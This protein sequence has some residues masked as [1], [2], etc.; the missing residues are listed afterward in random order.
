M[1]SPVIQW[2]PPALA[3]LERFFRARLA[4]DQLE[5]ADSA[6]LKAD[7][8]A[9]LEEELAQSGVS[10]V[11]LEDLRLVLARMGESLP[12]AIGLATPP[13]AQPAVAAPP[14][15]M[16]GI[17][18]GPTSPGALSH[19]RWFL[20][21]AV[22]LPLGTF[23]FEVL[24]RGGAGMFFDPMPDVWHHFLVL[25]VPGAG[26]AFWRAQKPDA[27]LRLRRLLPW[28][29]G[30]GCASAGFYAFCFLP[31]MPLAGLGIIWFGL[32]LLPLA[33][34]LAFLA[35]W[36]AR[37]L[38]K[39][40]E[41]RSVQAPLRWGFRLTAILIL[42]LELPGFLTH[43]G[44]HQA[45]RAG[46]DAEGWA[47]ATGFIRRFGSEDTLLRS[48]YPGRGNSMLG[49][50]S[51]KDPAAWL[52]GWLQLSPGRGPSPWN[53]SQTTSRELYYRVTG[54]PFN[55]LAQPESARP[56]IHND[57]NRQGSWRNDEDRGGTRVAGRIEG[58][59]LAE[60]R[61]D[62]HCE[63]ASG[64]TWGEWTLTF[65]NNT[66]AP[67][68]ARC[69]IALPPGGFVSRV[70]LWVNGQPE[71]AA[72]STVS[73]VRAAY[74]SVAVVQR[75]DPVLVTQPDAGS[76][77]VQAFP[78]P[79]RGQLKTRITFTVPA[80]TDSKVWLPSIVERNFEL[81]S[82]A[83]HPLWVQAD[84]GTLTLPAEAQ[85]RAAMEAG[86]P[87]VTGNL[88][89]ALFTGSGSSFTWG[90]Q[91]AD[92]VF[93]EDSFAAPEHRWVVRKQSAPEVF[94]P[95]A[96]AWV[97]DTSA[98]LAAQRESIAAAVT[99]LSL[100]GQS[101]V[102]LPGDSPAELKTLT[103]FGNFKPG[104]TGGRDNAPALTA[105]V[106][107][108]RG[109][110]GACLIWI[111]G[112][113][114]GAAASRGALEQ[115]LERSVAPFTLMDVPLVMGENTLAPVFAAL[116]RIHTL[117]VRH[118]GPDLAGSLRAALQQ[119]GGT[120]IT[121]PE[122]SNPP[123]G[124]VKTKDTLA[125][126]FAR[127]EASRLA[128]SDPPA[129]SALAAAHQIVSPWSGAVVLER[130]DDYAKHGLQQSSASV[131]QQIP[132]IPE[133]SGV[134]LMMLSAVPFILRRRRD[135]LCAR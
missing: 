107:W 115:L 121:L 39:R 92:T 86:A 114:P 77:L 129:A 122:G 127:T 58:L 61:I 98:P 16:P 125:R 51:G 47:S 24:T 45:N 42:W 1:T 83:L 84:R 55:D 66:G 48:C 78:V 106:D 57:W 64:L 21:L 15:V 79:A 113:Q 29:I 89:P 109:K 10:V 6:E 80:G 63:Q 31:V 59:S 117:P 49:S 11:T 41:G 82:R 30:A 32:G 70:T 60:G 22:F 5:G 46:A 75:R 94:Q 68:E 131:S 23:L 26:L 87:T 28:L 133:P 99:G 104:Y 110:P 44:I 108:L 9:H 7:L 20:F 27:S 116:P 62:W 91:P 102:F 73:K 95:G 12:P 34:F 37:T 119:R 88:P 81:P 2:T 105:A 19:T 3:G 126:W 90:H 103:D 8:H 111:H 52:A 118:A 123:E 69:R 65:A 38:L 67:E 25:L 97:I 18:V 100:P 43:L 53:A 135:C 33:P 101:A 36:R 35:L 128:L 71:E 93:A 50:A 14:P 112:P 76:V 13:A 40:S 96:I 54:V 56:V 85:P 17:P 72:Y 134:V 130:A 74:Q 120:F 124:A 4:P 132:A